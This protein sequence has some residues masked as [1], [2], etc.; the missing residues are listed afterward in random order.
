MKQPVPVT[1]E[2][3]HVRLVPLTLAHLDA[4]SAVGLDPE[5][6]HLIPSKAD[7]PEGMRV[8]VETALDEQRRGVSLPFVT[9]LKGTGQVIGST[10]Y[11]NI[12]VRNRRLEIGCTWIGKPWQRSVVNTEAKLLMLEQAFEVLGC[13]RVEL[14]TDFLNQQSRNAILRLGAKQEG[15]FR[16]HVLTWDGRMR[17]TV[18]FSIL[19]D[20]WPAL[21]AGLEAKLAA[22]P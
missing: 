22:R 3:A 13:V 11:M 4:F 21:R 7:T 8:Y 16:R 19:D 20:E 18:Y 12:D 14:K 2:G 6:W 10:R 5:L 17:D 1:L 9:T 15:I